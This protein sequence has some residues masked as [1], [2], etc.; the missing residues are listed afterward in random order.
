MYSQHE[1]LSKLLLRVPPIVLQQ[2]ARFNVIEEIQST[3][4]IEG[5]QSTRQ[6]LRETF[7]QASSS[8]RFAGIINRYNNL[9]DGRDIAF[10]TCID[11]RIFYN[12]FTYD[13]V[14]RAAPSNKLDGKIFRAGSVDIS[15]ASG[16]TIHR[17]LF[18]EENIISAMNAALH[19]LYDEKMPLLIRLAIFHYAFAYIHPFY[20]GNGRTGR[21]I[22]S[23]FLA[24]RFHFI[25]A[26]RLSYI[27][28]KNL[29]QYY[30]LFKL[31]DAEINC[32]DLT[33]F[34]TEF[35]SLIAATFD[36]V[37]DVLK[38]KLNQLDKLS[39]LLLPVVPNE[40]LIRKLYVLLLQTS[41][42][43]GYGLTLKELVALTGK[44]RNTIRSRLDAMP[45]EHLTLIK[46]KPFRFK[47]NA[48]IF[49]TL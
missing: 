13:E 10:D 20:D 21:F 16:K 27:L 43:Y 29:K 46:A 23:Y 22:V 49:K 17:G 2:F 11:I 47:L 15:S 1:S 8:A 37:S 45:P 28:K 30:E 31:T 35:V 24:K 36:N 19:I 14:L 44:S 26:L 48:N 18:P 34:I 39:N 40:P 7:E 33:P 41:S 4:D 25:V 12:T 42:F 32:G 5:V 6:E 3:N 9:V 38:R